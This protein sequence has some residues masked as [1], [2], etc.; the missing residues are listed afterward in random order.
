MQRPRVRGCR[1][2]VAWLAGVIWLSL[3]HGRAFAADPAAAD[4]EALR[5]QVARLTQLVQSLSDRDQAEI[6]ELSAQ[7]RSLQARLDAAQAANSAPAAQS[8]LSQPAQESPHRAVTE[9]S[10]PNEPDPEIAEPRIVQ[11]ATR[12]FSV[13]T[14]DGDYS[15][16]IYGIVQVDTGAYV[17]FRPESPFVGPQTLSNGVNARRARIGVAGTVARDWGYAFVYDAGNSSDATPR[18]LTTAQIMW[19]GPR[20]TAWELG[21]SSTYF[22]LDQSTGAADL[23]FLERASPSNIATSFNAG[24]AR[25]N[26]GARFF[27]ERYW[28]GAYLTGPQIGDSHTQSRERFGAI[29]RAT[30]QV[31]TGSDYS[32]HLGVG[33]SELLHAPNSGPGTPAAISLSDRP[34][35]RIDPTTFLDTGQIGTPANPVTKGYVIDVET[36]ATYRS[37]FWQGEYFHYQV[38]RAGLPNASFNGAYGQ[39]SWTLTGEAHPYNPQAGSYLRIRPRNPF[40]LKFGGWGAWEIAARFSY[41]NLNSNIVSGDLQSATPGAVLGGNQYGY[42]IGLNWY[43]N[44]LVR[45]MLDFNH[46]DFERFNAGNLVGVPLGAPIGA[47]FDAISLRAQVSY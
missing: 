31:A 40:S 18:G 17:D 20:G 9:V 29:E 34:E 6:R 25:A 7:V 21:Y 26:A 11:S 39:I 23:L 15:I 14:A 4:T 12:R 41:I 16:G 33:V 10:A 28:V 45:L 30:Y 44:D 24:S 2:P 46:I 47:K 1:K 27:G 43:P 3:G 32:I 38:D 8:A 22:T 36:A 19:T 37:L 42:T 13:Q 5:A 35:L